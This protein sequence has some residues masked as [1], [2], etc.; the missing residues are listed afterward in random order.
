MADKNQYMPDKPEDINYIG[1]QVHPTYLIKKNM[2]IQIA[3]AYS[4]GIIYK[5]ADPSYLHRF[6]PRETEKSYKARKERAVYRNNV[7]P[8]ADMFTGF[9]FSTDPARDKVGP[10][11]LI[12]NANQYLSMNEFMKMVALNSLMYTCGVLVDSPNFSVDEIQSEAD[13][14]EK[15]INPFCVL[16]APWQIRNY[17]VGKDGKLDWI[18]FDDTCYDNSEPMKLATLNLQFTL[19][20]RK[21]I[22]RF[23]SRS[24][25]PVNLSMY[26]M[27]GNRQGQFGYGMNVFNLYEF[28]ASASGTIIPGVSINLEAGKVI[29][30]PCGEIPF[31]FCNWTTKNRSHFVDTIFEDI[32][33]FDQAIYNYMSLMDEV[34]SGGVFKFLF[35]PGEPPSQIVENNG[36]SNCGILTFDP[37]ASQPPFFAGPELNEL[38]PFLMLIESLIIAIKLALGL[39]TDANKTTAQSGTAKAFDFSKVSAFL[40]MGAGAMED[41]EEEIFRFAGLWEGRDDD[42]AEIEYRKDIIG[43]DEDAE[44]ERLYNVMMLPY[45]VL[46]KYTAKRIA[47]LNFSD[48]LTS[49]EMQEIEDDIDKVHEEKAKQP[50][51]D[52]RQLALMAQKGAAMKNGQPPQQEGEQQL[53]ENGNPVQQEPDKNNAGE[54]KNNA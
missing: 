6:D 4:G 25:L 26:N 8:F 44:L 7:Q 32:T 2:W 30:H 53:D 28:G 46:K 11:Y 15:N 49:D 50:K 19:W 40:N 3:K 34:V 31:K 37:D 23:S 5:Y 35:W 1:L 43:K 13:R 20:T 17:H 16:Y 52:P 21:T 42:S 48:T 24:D 54:V 14:K 51:I 22:Q 29:N 27:L 18:V 45:E 9:I 12:D 36:L 33:L 39:D 47:K 41:I 10:E 38:Q